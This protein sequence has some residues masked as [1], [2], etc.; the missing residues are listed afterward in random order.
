MRQSW[1][2]QRASDGF[3]SAEQGGAPKLAAQRAIFSMIVS[4]VQRVDPRPPAL[5]AD[6]GIDS[7]VR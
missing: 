7:S 1:P 6:G 5:F 2:R 3:Q 4:R